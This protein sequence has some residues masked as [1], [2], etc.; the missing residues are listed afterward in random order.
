MRLDTEL[1][2]S[3]SQTANNTTARFPVQLTATLP[4]LTFAYAGRSAY[5]D[6]VPLVCPAAYGGT[7][8]L[9][10]DIRNDSTAPALS[11]RTRVEIRNRS[12]D[13]H[14]QDYVVTPAIP[15][16]DSVPFTY[17]TALPATG[18]AGN[19]SVFLVLDDFTTL[20][21]ASEFNNSIVTY[22][23]LASGPP[24]EG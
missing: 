1:V 12:N 7:L 18:T 24:A 17:S 13:I 11:T 8:Q 20:A 21:E 23:W 4:D 22:T 6:F 2:L 14:V 9:A 10:F 3:E 16:G 19:W 5:L 15:A